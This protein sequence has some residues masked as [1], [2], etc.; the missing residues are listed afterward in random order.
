MDGA[1][2][3]TPGEPAEST[4]KDRLC[5]GAYPTHEYNGIVFAYM[6]PP[7]KQPPFP[8]YDSFDRPGLSAHPRAEIFLPVQLAADHGKR[9]GPRPYGVS[10]HHRQWLPV[11]RRVRGVPE[12]EFTETPVGMIYIGTRRVKENVWARM[13]EAF[14][15][16]CSR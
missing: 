9:H 11:H 14:C 13:V 4:L 16:T 7:D 10:P 6:G 15:P 8:I 1:I 2:L 12:L 5:Q 3:E